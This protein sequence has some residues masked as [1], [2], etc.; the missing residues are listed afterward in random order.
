[1]FSDSTDDNPKADLGAGGDGTPTAEA[2][3]NSS[4]KKSAII[5]MVWRGGSGLQVCKLR[6]E[7]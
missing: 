7:K 6:S 3:A 1:M 4:S 2:E 5:V